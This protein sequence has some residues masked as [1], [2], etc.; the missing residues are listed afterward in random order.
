MIK[1]LFTYQV[2]SARRSDFGTRLGVAKVYL[3]DR[4]FKTH[5]NATCNKMALA[6]KHFEST[7]HHLFPIYSSRRTMY[8]FGRMPNIRAFTLR[9]QT[10]SRSVSLRVRVFVKQ[11]AESKLP[12]F[13]FFF[14]RLSY[15]RLGNFVLRT[16]MPPLSKYFRILIDSLP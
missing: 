13:F 12:S 16:Q 9:L 3:D 14:P 11:A 10:H 6:H 4:H 5:W 15:L 8:I 1:I 2:T 7:V